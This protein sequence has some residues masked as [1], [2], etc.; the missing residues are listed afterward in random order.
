MKLMK[1]QIPKNKKSAGRPSKNFWDCLRLKE[2]YNF[3][4]KPM[5][6]IEISDYKLAK[7]MTASVS[8]YLD[9]A[10]SFLHRIKNAQLGSVNPQYLSALSSALSTLDSNLDWTIPIFAKAH[11]LKIENEYERTG[12][13]YV[14]LALMQRGY[15]DAISWLSPRDIAIDIAEFLHIA[16]VDFI[17]ELEPATAELIF[18][19]EIDRQQLRDIIN[20]ISMTYIQDDPWEEITEECRALMPLLV[21][22][23]AMYYMPRFFI[24]NK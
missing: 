24:P 9:T 1:K 14:Y 16:N 5:R 18:S 21:T 12:P 19:D 10:K 13:Y 4:K 17:D 2:V 6:G 7:L 3:V 15:I 20:G 11:I 8:I 23:W 22:T